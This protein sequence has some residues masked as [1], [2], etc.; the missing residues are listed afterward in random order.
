MTSSTRSRESPATRS[1]AIPN[2]INRVDAELYR[3]TCL[4]DQIGARSRR[5]Y[6]QQSL[7]ILMLIYTILL[8]GYEGPATEVFLHR[9]ENTL[10]GET[11]SFGNAASDL[12]RL[13]LA[14]E[15]FG[16]EVFSWHISQLVDTCFPLG[17]SSWKY[18]KEALLDF[19]VH[20]IACQGPLQDLWKNRIAAIRGEGATDKL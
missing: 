16:S 11:S 12:F 9:F 1:L 7:Y 17:W 20:D 4:P 19:F 14:S 3:L 8:S 13:L 6:L 5:R 2:T 15:P 18:V 10:S